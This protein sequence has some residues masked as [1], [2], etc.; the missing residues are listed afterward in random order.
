MKH[1]LNKEQI[2]ERD[3]QRRNNNKDKQP[4]N[5]ETTEREN[6]QCPDIWRRLV[7]DE[8][9]FCGMPHRQN[10]AFQHIPQYS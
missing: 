8:N 6:A 3:K 5:K 2:N 4:Y 1:N 7:F 10:I 9:S